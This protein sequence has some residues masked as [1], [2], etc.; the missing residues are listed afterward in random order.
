ML[1]QC[2]LRCW[3]YSISAVKF[4]IKSILDSGEKID[5]S[6]I[7]VP[8]RNHNPETPFNF[9]AQSDLAIIYCMLSR[10]CSAYSIAKKSLVRAL[11]TG[12]DVISPVPFHPSYHLQ[13][14][15][16]HLFQESDLTM[17]V[18]WG[19]PLRFLKSISLVQQAFYPRQEY[20]FHL[21]KL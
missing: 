20:F 11:T 8:I 14:I 9:S 1:L 5:V 7:L 21:S 10:V 19:L 13:S 16:M 2:F 12:A 15:W 6:L 4:P 3:K 17:R 18:F